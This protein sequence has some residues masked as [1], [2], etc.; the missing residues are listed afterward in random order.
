MKKFFLFMVAS[1]LFL[2]VQSQTSKKF[3]FSAG[4]GLGTSFAYSAKENARSPFQFAY[5]LGVSGEYFFNDSHGLKAGLLYDKKGWN[6]GYVK[7]E[8]EEMFETN[9]DLSYLLIPITYNWHYGKRKEWHVG[10]GPYVGFIASASE[11]RFRTDLRNYINNV[12]GGL[13]FSLGYQL[14]VSEK[15]KLAFRYEAQSGLA[16]VFPSGAGDDVSLRK[17]TLGAALLFDL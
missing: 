13:F 3:Q 5:N 14:P 8:R 16:R 7:N 1:L 11:S 10:F 9:F 6:K 15:I 2:G 4:F 17:S 12:D